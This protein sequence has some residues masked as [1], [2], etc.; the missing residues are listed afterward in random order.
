M[1]TYKLTNEEDIEALPRGEIV[2]QEAVAC[3]E[4]NRHPGRFATC[5]L[6]CWE[7]AERA[8]ADA[9]SAGVLVPILD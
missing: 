6:G 2:E 9:L 3:H 5:K 7:V 1:T 4:S 8:F